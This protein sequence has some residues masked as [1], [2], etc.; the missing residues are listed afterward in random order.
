[1]LVKKHQR[2]RIKFPHPVSPFL[3]S[4]RTQGTVLRVDIAV[5]ICY[6]VMGDA[7]AKNCKAKK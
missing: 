2:I 4:P 7:Y 3:Q 1:M 6:F 5:I